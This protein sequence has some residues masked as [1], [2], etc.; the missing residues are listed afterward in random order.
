M[1]NILCIRLLRCIGHSAK[2]VNAVHV[3]RTNVSGGIMNAPTTRAFRTT[4]LS[5]VS[6]TILAV[7]SLTFAQQKLKYAFSNASA[8][9]KY[10]EQHTLDVGDIPGHQIRI[11]SLQTKYTGDAPEYDGVKVAE[12]LG[13]LT[14]DYINGSGRFTQHS[15]LQMKNGDKIFTRAEGLVQTSMHPEGGK[16]TAF[17][18]VTTI[19]GGTGKFSTIRGTIRGSGATDFK[20]GPVNNPSEGEYWFEK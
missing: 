9:A 17:S 16:S 15:V 13:W 18:T 20:T 4:L 2:P 5:F 7:P 14:S 10:V 1:K 19:T 11:A 6:A 3:S 12:A 8:T